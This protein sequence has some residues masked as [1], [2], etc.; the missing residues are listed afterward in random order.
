MTDRPITLR[1]LS[2][3]GVGELKGVG[4]RRVAALRELGIESILDLVTYYPRRW[5]DRTHEARVRD[6][7][8]GREALVLVEV[9]SVTKRQTR[10]RRAMVTAQV[11]DESG[12]MSV[13]FFNQPWRERQLMPGLQVALFGKPEEYRGAL[14]MTNPVVDLIGDRT[15]R[16]VPIYPQSEKAAIHTWELAE[17]VEQALRRCERR[18]IADPVPGEVRRRLGLIDRQTALFGIHLPAIDGRQGRGQAPAGVRRAAAGPARPR[19]AQAGPR[20]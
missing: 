15:G 14:Q 20:A 17:L 12:R 6:L 10:Q 7:V 19:G 1:D 4:D 11:G 16:I 8:P 2:E 18:G 5:V 13:V 3:K 9:R